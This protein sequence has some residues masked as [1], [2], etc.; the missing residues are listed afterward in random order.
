MFWL[1]CVPRQFYAL[2]QG[3]LQHINPTG[4]TRVLPVRYRG[5]AFLSWAFL[6]FSFS[7]FLF[8]LFLEKVRLGRFVRFDWSSLGLGWPRLDWTG[9]LLGNSGSW[10]I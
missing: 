8:C 6:F 1:A 4:K 5:L 10:V 3:L 9:H 2:F 7:S